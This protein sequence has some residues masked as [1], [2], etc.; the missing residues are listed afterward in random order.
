MNKK[1]FI[2][3]VDFGT[4][5]ARAIVVDGY[6]GKILGEAQQSYK[7]WAEGK[8]QNPDISMYRQHPLDYIEA[9]EASVCSALDAA[10]D[11][12]RKNILCL[13]I[14]TTGST[15]CPVNEE[16]TPLALL[17]EFSE[18][19]NAMFHL[20]KDHTAI[21]EAIEI[22]KAFSDFDGI[23]YTRYQGTYCSEWYWA[24]IL[25]TSRID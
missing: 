1:K 18:N 13:S 19:E 8:Y 17:K 6:D 7:R 4:D 3:G 14:D 12:V 24:K 23:D 11:D 22:D 5:S 10:G 9:F 21:K 20:W 16:G 2:V 15:P 25:H